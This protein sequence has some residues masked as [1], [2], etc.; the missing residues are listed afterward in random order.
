MLLW[1]NILLVASAVIGMFCIAHKKRVGFVIFFLVEL[2]MAYIGEKTGNH[3]LTTAAGI[4]LAMNIYSWLKWG[5]EYNDNS[6]TR[7]P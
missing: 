3:G 7:T 2:C 5:Q 6:K 1:A 4:Y